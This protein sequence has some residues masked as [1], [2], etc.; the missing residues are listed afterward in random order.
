MQKYLDLAS[1][2]RAPGLPAPAPGLI[3]FPILKLWES[4]QALRSAGLSLNLAWASPACAVAIAL[5]T[6][7]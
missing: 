3:H 6:G 2:D 4:F 5:E 1:F 7:P